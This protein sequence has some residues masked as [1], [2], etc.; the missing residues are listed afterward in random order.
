MAGKT[1]ALLLAAAIVA[2]GFAKHE[3]RVREQTTLGRIASEIAGRP[4]G[5]RCPSFLGGLVDIHGDAGRVQFDANGHP[6]DH[7]DLSPD[8]CRELR[9]L[10]HTS[11]ACIASRS[12]GYAQF[13]AAWAAHALAHEAFH[14]R[15]VADEGVAECYA[16]QNTA[17]VAERLGV[18]PRVAE[19]LQQWVWD[20]GY[21]NEPDEY[22]SG[23]CAAGGPLDLTPQTPGWP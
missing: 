14:L 17:F 16:M 2:A 10:P 1:L 7:T 13:D 19:R 20:R 9:R 5:V 22:R 8:T 12:C 11:F 3:E 23:A 4:V 21:A 18:R 6:A 15:G